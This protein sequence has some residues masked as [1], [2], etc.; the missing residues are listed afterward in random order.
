MIEISEVKVQTTWTATTILSAIDAHEKG[1]FKQSALLADHYGRDERIS[2]CTADRISALTGEDSAPFEFETSDVDQAASASLIIDLEAFWFDLMTDAWIRVT[3]FDL[4]HMGV[5]ISHVEWELGE[6]EWRP[7]KLT[8]IHL[9]NIKWDHKR[10]AYILKD[11]AGEEI[12]IREGDPNWKIVAPDGDRSWMGGAVRSLGLYYLMR[13]WDF[14]DFARYNERHGTPILKVF[15]AVTGDKEAKE[16]FFR[17]LVAMGS[18][19]VIRIPRQPD[20]E[21]QMGYDVEPMEMKSR[22]YDAF[23][24]FGEILATAIAIRILGQNLSTEVQGGSYAAAGWHARVKQSIVRGDASSIGTSLRDL[25]KDYALM[26]VETFDV[27]A[28]PW[29]RWRLV[30]PEDLQALATTMQAAYQAIP[31]IIESGADIDVNA[32][33]KKFGV[34]LMEGSGPKPYAAPEGGDSGDDDPPEDNES[35]TD[36]TEP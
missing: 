36:E 34:P 9:S 20:E 8:R 30:M 28:A 29:P 5:S 17:D 22:T 32:Y 15:E 6:A 7:V 35:E 21:P 11:A 12:E 1:D 13:S 33:A 4:I 10:K 23:V 19:G 27:K 14:K 18:K 25:I 2:G 26:N 31:G 16:K 24:K 3:A